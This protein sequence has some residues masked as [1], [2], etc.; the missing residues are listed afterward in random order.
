MSSLS[1]IPGDA[2][3]NLTL[4]AMKAVQKET[5][6]EISAEQEESLESL[7]QSEEE[8]I[9]PFAQKLDKR[10]KALEA[11]RAR[12]SQLFGKEEE[13]PESLLPVEQIRGSAEKFQGRNP[14]LRQNVLVALR[15][16]IKPDATAE[17]ILRIIKGY[18]PDAA[19]AD[20][21]LAFLLETTDGDLAKEVQAAKDQLNT[22]SS[23]EIAAGRNIASQARAAAEKGLG[24]AASLR[25]MY[26][27]LTGNP[28]DSPSLFEELSTKYA[29]KDLQKV[30]G[31]L[32][33]S[34]GADMKSKGPSIPRGMLHR[35]LTETRSLQA[36]LGVYRFF[37]GRMAL[38][39]KLFA[40]EGLTKPP[41]MTFEN[42]AKQFMVLAADRYPSAA[43]VLQ[44]AV[45][46]GIEEWILAKIIAFSQ[47]RDAIRQVAINQIYKSLQHRDDLYLAILEALEDL[48]DELE[49]L[50]EKEEREKDEEEGEEEE[51]SSQ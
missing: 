1:D 12:I 10:E 41:Q 34:L 4:E 11:Q 35:L 51:D 8:L 7:Q 27:D 39:D 20:E 43:K 31:F 45:K 14:E 36:I 21:A 26:Y 29:F 18:Y 33:H 25:D 49:D 22:E 42:L 23:R 9:N 32:L 30:I 47:Y 17:D 24:T 28:R 2:S 16:Q 13:L 44:Q 38:V 3:V 37:R 48:E 19:L 5:A 15:E 6:A 46:L 40:K 50:A